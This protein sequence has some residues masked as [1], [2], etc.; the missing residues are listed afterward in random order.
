V[1]N[2]ILALL[3]TV[4][5][6]IGT[7]AFAY[8]EEDT[9]IYILPDGGN[10]AITVSGEIAGSVYGDSLLVIRFINPGTDLES[11]ADDIEEFRDITN[12]YRENGV[13]KYKFD[14]LYLPDNLDTATYKIVVSGEDL[15]VPLTTEYTYYNP[16]DVRGA[17]EALSLATKADIYDTLA[18]KIDVLGMDKSLFAAVRE[19]GKASFSALMKN[20]ADYSGQASADDERATVIAANQ[21]IL[22]RIEPIYQ[23]AVA[24]GRF[25]SIKNSDEVNN[26]LN[27]YY[28]E[29]GF[30]DSAEV[31]S[32]T[33]FLNKVKNTTDF[34]N[35]IVNATG[36]MSIEQIKTY[37]Y[38]SALLATIK[39]RSDTD[40]AN[41]F[42][43]CSMYFPNIDM[44]GF[45]KLSEVDKS[46]VIDYI[47]DNSYPSIA[48]AVKAFNDKVYEIANPDDDD[49]DSYSGGGGGG[50]R[51]PSV[52][53]TPTEKPEDTLTDD[54]VFNDIDSVLWAS[55][56]IDY[57]YQKGIV[58]GKAMGVFAPND[59]VTRAE[60]IKMVVEALGL[61]KSDADMP[62]TDVAADSWYASYVKAAYNAGVVNGDDN[63][64]FN[65]EATIT[66]EDMVTILYRA[67]GE[68]S[69]DTELNFT[70][71]ETISDYAKEAVAHFA[72]AGIVNGMGDG[73]FGAQE[74]ATRAQTAVIIYRII[75]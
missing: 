11:A 27:E 63:G 56:A 74:S 1:K 66:R 52:T 30:D 65:P 58:N 75:K 42:N 33:L 29:L 20:E 31:N 48:D 40:V 15:S 35:R 68:N 45:S 59:Q 43:K 50:F 39:E 41:M 44:V 7:I 46:R 13:V 16:F 37:L 24:A 26:W 23:R 3:M 55:D 53:E 12:T 25:M 19:D 69:K 70:D 21:T 64:L 34:I 38:D 9:G 28:N 54:K 2:K 47:S 8:A 61:D 60:F 32:I 10:G 5:I 51:A 67:M 4:V 36:E 18:S 22:T 62:F 14:K 6:C 71:E 49:D 57:L 17:I 73:R 72:K